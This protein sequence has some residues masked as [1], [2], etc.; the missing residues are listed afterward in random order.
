MTRPIRLAIAYV[1]T[2]AFAVLPRCA[3]AILLA[4]LVTLAALPAVAS[5]DTI[6]STLAGGPWQAGSTWQGGIVP[7]SDDQVI[8]Q[9]PVQVYGSAACLGL[10]VTASGD[11]SNVSSGVSTL[12]VGT[13]VSNQGSIQHGSQTLS[14]EVGGDIDNQGSWTNFE[15]VLTGPYDHHVNASSGSVFESALVMDAGATGDIVV[16]TPFAILGD[17]DTGAGRMLL[18][19]GCALTLRGGRFSGELLAGGNEVHFESWSYLSFA[20]VDAAVLVGE[21]EV[22]SQVSFTGGLTVMDVLQNLS[23]S[24]S[25]IISVSGG[26]VNHGEIRNQTYGLTVNLA[27]DLVCNGVI[28]CSQLLLDGQSIHHLSMGP[29]GNLDTALFL[30]EFGNGTIVAETDL[31]VSGSIG[32]GEAG[33]LILEPGASLRFTQHGGMASGTVLADGNVIRMNGLGVLSL[34]TVD[35]PVLRG[36]FKVG[37]A[38]TFTGTAVVRDTL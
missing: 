24:G 17:V 2:H 22:S 5:A 4:T 20:T 34:I 29:Q 38:C 25:A 26:L 16:E 1:P 13:S 19:S 28:S 35:Q 10:E 27:G 15:T 3:L 32:L 21:V 23:S 18:A 12:S 31:Q 7:G 14:I 37:P 8:V 36:A 33:T 11:V 9:G 30:P 6:T